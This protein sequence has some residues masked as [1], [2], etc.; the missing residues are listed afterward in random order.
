MIP[1]S[2]LVT[3]A[4]T[5]SFHIKGEYNRDRPSKFSDVFRPVVTWN[6]TRK[7]NLK[8]LHCYINASP[9][10]EDGLTTEEALGLIDEMAE[11]KI[12]L[13]IMSGGEPL[14]RRDFFELASY[15]RSKGI[16]LALSTNGT[17]ISESVAKRL[18]ELD[19][20]YVGISLDS[21]D[22]EFHDKFRGLNGAFN[23]TVKGIG[24][25]INVGL[26]VGLRFTITAK[27]IHQVDEYMKLALKLGVKRITFYHLSAS[28][29]G[30]ELREWMYTL[31]EYVSFINKMIDYAI[32]LSGKIE[33]E[34]TLGQFDGVYIAKKLARNEEELEKYLKFVENSGGCGRKMISIY[35][36][37]DV[38]PCQFID[39]YKLG[40]VREKPLKEIIKNIPDLFINTDKYLKGRYCDKCEYKS[41]CKGGDRARA[42]YWNEDIYGDDPLCP[43]K[44]LHI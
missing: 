39:F 12:P 33:I 10:G 4:G 24:N 38:Y 23:M 20:S 30:R 5:V 42:Y 18:K 15:A 3:N 36:N 28:G 37:G 11:M 41:A 2:V 8:C 43:L 13:I 9:E 29:R 14:M 35:P 21:Y 17:L 44:T 16:K 7:C 19:F 25:A 40:N 34:T 32:K 26:N 6:L 1:I 31:E 27:N 22:P